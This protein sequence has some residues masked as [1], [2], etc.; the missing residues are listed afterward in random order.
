MR[1][2]VI[3]DAVHEV[4]IHTRAVEELIETALVELSALQS[5][6]VQVSNVAGV[7]YATLQGSFEGV[8]ATIN[9]LVKVRGTMAGC[10]EIFVETK[11]RIPGVRTTSWG[12]G[13]PCCGKVAQTDLRVVA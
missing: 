1:K 5:K 13:D 11:E 4:G 10:H 8:S 2:Q 6:L 9:D 7:T 3:W 12:D